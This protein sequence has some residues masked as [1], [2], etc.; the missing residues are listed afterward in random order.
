M[1]KQGL[2]SGCGCGG[3][4]SSWFEAFGTLFS[5]GW[6][7]FNLGASVELI[8]SCRGAAS[9]LL[10]VTQRLDVQVL[11]LIGGHWGS[12]SKRGSLYISRWTATLEGDY[13]WSWVS[14]G[15][16]LLSTI[17]G[18]FLF[19]RFVL[20]FIEKLL[21]MVFFIYVTR[22]ISVGIGHH[23]RGEELILTTIIHSLDQNI[24]V[25]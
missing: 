9:S 14:G 23:N 21:G 12:L 16:L 7:Y 18:F 3:C 19:K 8:G 10:R 25:I 4:S 15:L 2:S 22:L 11:R 5:E 6:G 13:G 1:I 17:L 20:R 24:R